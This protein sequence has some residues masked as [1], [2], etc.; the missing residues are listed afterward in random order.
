MELFAYSSL[1]QL[2]VSIHS[3]RA[4]LNLE[5]ISG[6][7]WGYC[8]SEIL[9]NTLEEDFVIWKMVLALFLRSS[10]S[11]S[12]WISTANCSEYF[13][14]G[15]SF[16]EA[17]LKIR[18]QAACNLRKQKVIRRKAVCNPRKRNVIYRRWYVINPKDRKFPD[19]IHASPDYI[20]L[21]A[22][23]YQSFG[24]YK[25]KALR[26]KCFIFWSC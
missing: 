13:N 1:S 5:S 26:K 2:S 18:R 16:I 12:D 17:P 14:S 19:A 24:L 7:L 8:A 3:L 22:L 6:R 25:N 20:R 15:F 21:T 10:V 11:Q 4:I 23:T 9:A